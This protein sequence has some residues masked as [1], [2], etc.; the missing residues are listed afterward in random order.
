MENEKNEGLE[1]PAMEN[2]VFTQENLSGLRT[3][4]NYPLALVCGLLAAIVGAIVWA[5]ITVV[6]QYQ[7]G[8]MAVGVGFIVGLA[9]RLGKGVG[10]H[11]ALTGAALA[12]FGCLLGD[13]IGFVAL[14]GNMSVIEVIADFHNLSPKAFESVIMLENGDPIYSLL[15]YGIAISCGY[16]YSVLPS[17]NPTSVAGAPTTDN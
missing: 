12:L 10:V 2:P 8:F 14:E 5:T 3:K 1:N 11:F 6:T 17:K 9:M 4:Q 16:R 13:I 15:F 7:I